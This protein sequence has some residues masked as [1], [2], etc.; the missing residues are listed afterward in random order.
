MFGPLDYSIGFRW[1]LHVIP[2]VNAPRT[3]TATC[4]ASNICKLLLSAGQLQ[5]CR[6]IG[7]LSVLDPFGPIGPGPHFPICS[8]AL[9]KYVSI[10]SEGTSN[11]TR[12]YSL[13]HLAVL[14][15]SAGQGLLGSDRGRGGGAEGREGAAGGLLFDLRW[16][17]SVFCLNEMMEKACQSI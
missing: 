16:E 13:V 8:S 9:N 3:L 14:S 6:L 10:C 15:Q 1:T 12:P 17:G 4:F 7:S 2:I 11:W 5:P